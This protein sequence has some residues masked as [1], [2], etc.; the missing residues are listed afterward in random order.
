MYRSTLSLT[1]VRDGVRWPTAQSCRFNPGTFYKRVVGPR[2]GLDGWVTSRPN[3]DSNPDLPVHSLS[4]YRLS[5]R[6]PTTVACVVY[7]LRA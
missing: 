3:R 4:L 1:S 6:G 2:D 7:R 5:Y